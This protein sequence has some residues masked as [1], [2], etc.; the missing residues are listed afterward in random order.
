MHSEKPAEA[1]ADCIH[2]RWLASDVP[3]TAIKSPLG[4]GY[5]VQMRAENVGPMVIA[6]AI[7]DG[8]GTTVNFRSWAFGSWNL[9]PPTRSCL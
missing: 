8:S 6:D 5:T 7:P 9:E 3:Y 4:D 2:S 1:V